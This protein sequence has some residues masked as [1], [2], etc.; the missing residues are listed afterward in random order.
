MN[1]YWHGIYLPAIPKAVAICCYLPFA[2]AIILVLGGL[3]LLLNRGDELLNFLI[4]WGK[5]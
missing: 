3:A 5:S 1:K 2:F 4:P